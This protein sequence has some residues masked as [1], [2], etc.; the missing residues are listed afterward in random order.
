M[1]LITTRGFFSIVEKPGDRAAGMLTIRARVRA[2]LEALREVLPALGDITDKGGTDYPFRARAPREAVAAAMAD[3]VATLDYDNFKTAVADRQGQEREDTYH[4]VWSVLYALKPHAQPRPR[5]RPRAPSIPKATAYGGVL[6]DA[7]GRVLLRE[8]KGHFGG[9]VWTFP[10]GNPDKSETPDQTALREVR[11]ETGY[12][13]RIVAPIEQVFAGTTSTSAFFLME[14]MG[15]PGPPDAET[16]AVRWVPFAEAPALIGQTKTDV[17]RA[18]DL[19]IL[20]AADALWQA[21]R[22]TTP[23]G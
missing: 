12:R 17:G 18:R 8:P 3:L 2:D 5:N 21:Q 7:A 10:K 11:E 16:A 9:Y 20:A 15:E 4:K 13:A 14:P 23:Q 19:A 6:V 1:W 22:G